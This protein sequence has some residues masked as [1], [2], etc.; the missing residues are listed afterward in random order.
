MLSS[1]SQR[2]SLHLRI[3]PSPY[4]AQIL[5]SPESHSPSSSTSARASTMTAETT[6]TSESPGFILCSA[7]CLYDFS[8][9]D[10]DHLPFHKNEILEIVKQE[11][12]GW[13]AA[14]RI[15]GGAVGWI[16]QAFV[17]PL[18]DEMAD[19][20]RNV[21]VDLR[22]YEYEAEHLYNSLRVPTTNTEYYAPS[23][24]RTGRKI[25]RKLSLQTGLRSASESNSGYNVYSKPY[26]PPSPSTPMPQPPRIPS[27]AT[28]KEEPHEHTSPK[29]SRRRPLRVDD[30]DT[31]HRLSTL[32]ETQDI[33]ELEKIALTENT[34]TKRTPLPNGKSN[35]W[36][37]RVVHL[38]Q[39][40]TPSYLKAAYQDQLQMEG[41]KVQIGTL[42]ALVEKL[43]L[44][45]SAR[46]SVNS[47]NKLS[48]DMP[49]INAF[50]MTF[51]TF[52]TAGTLFEMLVDRYRMDHPKDLTEAEFED[53]KLRCLL[54]TQRRVLTVFA[55]WLEDH[56]LL[57]EDTDIAKRLTD[58]LNLIVAPP[59][60]TT[61]KLL[62]Q[63]IERLT[64][65]TPQEM[66]TPGSRRARKGKHKNDLL[67]VDATDLAEQLCLYEYQMYVKITPQE[68]LAYMKDKNGKAVANMNTFCSTY[69]RMV[70]WVKASILGHESLGKRADIV[71]YWIK[72]A[73]KSRQLNNFITMTS[74]TTALLS[75]TVDRLH[76]TWAHVG[77][78]SVFESLRKNLDPSNG[79]ASLRSPL[80]SIEAPCIPFIPMFLTELAHLCAQYSD[81]GRYICFYQR[82]RWYETIST[83]LRFQQ[84]PYTYPLSDSI[85]S[86]IETQLKESSGRDQHWFWTRS[87]E[88]QQLEL[89]H[90]DIRKGLEAAGF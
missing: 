12:S 31:L 73:D 68:C 48:E 34:D 5:I 17:V 15:I 36:S 49:Y 27:K 46:D 32:I 66:M 60:A 80:Q 2:Q 10:P 79:F 9:S 50:L 74:I 29:Q 25:N 4:N 87:Q 72:V 28:L 61:A 1:R 19:R 52:T 75:S 70:A 40:Q 90:A 65:A 57:E 43:S 45:T 55:M 14:T 62:I 56:R 24:Y 30:N 89:A 22:C 67:R 37:R 6:P 20:L 21:Q 39:P 82:Q 81:D 3:D 69:D 63:T 11:D 41:G 38:Q 35:D 51:R 64:F 33:R 59:L 47:V 26:A 42:E 77:R 44:D 18:S 83:M 8:S 86:F 54:P 16:P 84:K 58:F 53:W 76:L 7:L 78:K 88:L 13:W 85:R 23:N 71:D